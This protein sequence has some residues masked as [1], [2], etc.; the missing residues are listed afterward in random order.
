MGQS[1][2]EM[3]LILMVKPSQVLSRNS[4]TRAAVTKLSGL[5]M[6]PHCDCDLKVPN[7]LLD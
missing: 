5:A 4:A 6:Q 3:E 7:L 1:L 2:L